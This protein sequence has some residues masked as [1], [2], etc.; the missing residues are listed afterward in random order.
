MVLYIP[1]TDGFSGVVS[2]RG[3]SQ[4]KVEHVSPSYSYGFH[5]P[6]PLH[7]KGGV[8]CILNVMGISTDANYWSSLCR[9]DLD[10]RG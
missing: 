9:I 1:L 3:L 6:I 2:A 4:S 10:A 5:V 8:L 7:D